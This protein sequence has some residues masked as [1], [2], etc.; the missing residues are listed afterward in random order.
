MCGRVAGGPARRAITGAVGP[1][2]PS[3]FGPRRGPPTGSEFHG[4]PNPE[5]LD[6]AA[7]GTGR[8]GP[9]AVDV[10][11]LHLD[12]RRPVPVESDGVLAVDAALDEVGVQVEVGVP[13]QQLPGARPEP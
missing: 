6:V 7:H 13:V 11:E 8:H 5:T 3:R 1:F 9:L 10:V 2:V 12:V 4:A